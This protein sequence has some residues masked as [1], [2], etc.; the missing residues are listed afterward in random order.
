MEHNENMASPEEIRNMSE[1]EWQDYRNKSWLKKR[2]YYN[3][4]MPEWYLKSQDGFASFLER[5]EARRSR[6]GQ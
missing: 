2:E 5:Q 1:A 6:R 4:D 3:K